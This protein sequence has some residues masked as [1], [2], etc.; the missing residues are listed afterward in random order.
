MVHRDLKPENLMIGTNSTLKI[1]D[2]GLASLSSANEKLT[3]ELGTKGYMAPEIYLQQPYD[4]QVTDLFAAGV[5]L[6]IMIAGHSPFN[7]ATNSDPFYKC[8]AMNR[9]EIF[10]KVHSKKLPEDT[11][12]EDLKNLF[13]NMFELNPEKRLTLK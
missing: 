7:E 6:F 5:I 11:I 8:L 3:G 2:F 10:W 9:P 13:T 12:S 4:G 1:A